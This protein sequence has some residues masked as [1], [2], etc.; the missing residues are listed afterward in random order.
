VQ[1]L[2]AEV[3]LTPKPGLVDARGPGAHHDLSIEIFERSAVALGPY[4]AA[5]ARAAMLSAPSLFLRETL[6]SIGRRAEKAMLASTGGANTHRGAIWTMGLL[7]AS[8]APGAASAAEV[9]ERAAILAALPDRFSPEIPSHGRAALL[10][11]GA[12]GARG[13]AVAGF[14]H[15]QEKGLPA[16]RAARRSGAPETNARLDALLAI[17]STLDD[18]CLLHRG[19]RDALHAAQRGAARVLECGGSATHEGARRLQALDETLLTLWASPGGAADLFSATL[20]LDAVF[21]DAS[22]P[23]PESWHA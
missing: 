2:L 18:T 12:R 4:F 21:P 3:R 7:V 8:S 6:G 19:G 1:A 23:S 22:A 11:F 9:C 14:P 15:I 13:E 10:T 17:M 5:I 16:L 20:F